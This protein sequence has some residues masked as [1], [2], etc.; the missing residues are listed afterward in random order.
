MSINYPIYLDNHA[1]TQVDQKVL[2][3]MLPYFT[4]IY[5]NA[6][7]KNHKYGN[8]ASTAVEKARSQVANCLNAKDSEIIFTSGATESINL[9]T[10]GI[11]EYFKNKNPHF[12]TVTTEHKATLDCHEWLKNNGYEVTL[13]DVDSEGFINLEDLKKA[14]KDNT[15][16]VSIMTANNEIGT[17]QPIADI[18]KICREANC[19]F[20]TD[21]TQAI[22]K[23][24]LDVESMNID[25]LAGSGHKIHGPKGIG[26]LY[27]RRSNPH[28]YL[29]EQIN[30]G[31]HERSM[32]SGTLNVPGI[33]GLGQ[34]IN[35]S[36]KDFLTHNKLI[37][38]MRDNI[39]NELLINIK[40]SKVN[41]PKKEHRLPNNLNI[42]LPGVEAEALIISLSDKISFSSGSA[43]TTASIEPSH[44]L[45]AIGLN[46]SQIHQSIRIGLSKKTTPDQI[47]ISTELMIQNYKKIKQLS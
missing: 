39:E 9:A 10:K 31:K 29:K 43:C 18:G 12:I 16:L 34:A 22:G 40:N 23:L 1:T 5:G 35:Q 28:V 2:E 47:H 25:L 4:E 37:S 14:I 11:A 33:V 13:L 44:A 26:F 42:Y 7:S 24:K 30:G 21:A 41:G 6:S 32:R 20:M 8:D 45:K 38:E 46:D 27:V 19:Y 17:I 36:S 15:K 3:V